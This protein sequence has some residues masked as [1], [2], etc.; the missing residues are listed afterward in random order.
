MSWASAK[1]RTLAGTDVRLFGIFDAQWMRWRNVVLCLHH[2]HLYLGGH[3]IQVSTLKLSS[4]LKN[5]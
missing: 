4:P 1:I 5:V 3:F 2:H